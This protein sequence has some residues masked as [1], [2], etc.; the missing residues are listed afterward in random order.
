M[1]EPEFL[2]V[3]D[4]ET[5]QEELILRY[6]GGQGIRD[7]GSLES[8]VAVPQAFFGEQFAH[9][10]LF[11]MAAAYAFHLCQNHPFVDGNKRTALATALVFLEMN[12]ITIEDPSGS[13]YDA[14]IEVADGQLQKPALAEIFRTLG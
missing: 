2:T 9:S 8:A 11:E 3:S 1:T 14:M 10:D 6:G 13:L 7:R 4:V 5:L 12:G